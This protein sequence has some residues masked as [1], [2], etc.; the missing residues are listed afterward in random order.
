MLGTMVAG[1]YSATF[2]SVDVGFTRQGFELEFMF[3]Q[4]VI[5]ETDL[6]GMST[7]DAVLR[8]ADGFVSAI[9]RE[10]KA[11]PKSILWALGGG[12]LGKVFSAAVPNGVFASD[13]ALPFVMTSTANTPAAADPATLTASKAF[14]A[15]NYNPRIL[16]DSRLRETPIRFQMFPYASSTDTILFS[17][18]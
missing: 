1:R 13:K 12:V 15:P 16:F 4:E 14:I 9:L 17:T 6:Y 2:N 7:I 3:K 10:W 18:P 5:D 11:G 8:G